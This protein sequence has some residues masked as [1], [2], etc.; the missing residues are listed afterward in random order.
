MTNV[1]VH[2]AF[3]TNALETDD[4]V[5]I[6]IAAG[7]ALLFLRELPVVIKQSRCHNFI[8]WTVLFIRR[9]FDDRPVTQ[10]RKEQRVR[11]FEIGFLECMATVE[12]DVFLGVDGVGIN[13]HGNVSRSVVFDAIHGELL[14]RPGDRQLG[15]KLRK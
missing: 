12:H 14:T 13:Q 2:R 3:A 4:A 7:S 6:D 9:Q 10:S 1:E 15:Q 11:P 5:A 8:R